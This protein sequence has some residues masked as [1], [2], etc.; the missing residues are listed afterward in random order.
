MAEGGRN[1][2]AF[3]AGAVVGQL[4]AAGALAAETV[5]ADMVAAACASGL[6]PREAENAIRNGIARGRQ[7][8][9]FTFPKE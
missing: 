9:P 4:D 6:D 1:L 3:R 5:I 2:A 7:D 8:G